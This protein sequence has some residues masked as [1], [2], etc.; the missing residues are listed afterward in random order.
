MLLVWIFY[1]NFLPSI[2]SKGKFPSTH[3]HLV[4]ICFFWQAET[5]NSSN[6]YV[7]KCHKSLTAAETNPVIREIR[8]RRPEAI[9]R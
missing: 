5:S 2:V 8:R 4:Q 9:I 1:K 3:L 7:S 6:T